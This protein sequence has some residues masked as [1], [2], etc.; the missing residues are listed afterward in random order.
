MQHASQAY[1]I[2]LRQHIGCLIFLFQAVFL[3]SSPW[4]SSGMFGHQSKFTRAILLEAVTTDRH[5]QAAK[6]L[7]APQLLVYTPLVYVWLWGGESL[8][9][10]R[11]VVRSDSSLA[12]QLRLGSNQHPNMPELIP[13]ANSANNTL[14]ILGVAT[15]THSTVSMKPWL[16][17]KLDIKHVCLCQFPLP[18][19]WWT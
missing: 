7:P 9:R 2:L 13:T 4:M 5:P 17:P 15:L 1:C 16:S 6:A 10:P 14:P 3:L 8:H 19:G 11:S 12:E 18:V